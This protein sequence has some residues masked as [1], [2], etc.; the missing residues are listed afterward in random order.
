MARISRERAGGFLRSRPAVRYLAAMA[1]AM[2]LAAG[3]GTRLRPL[4]LELPKPLVWVGDRPAIAHVAGRLVAA[5]VTELVVNTHHRAEAFSEAMLAR[6][7]GRLSIVTEAEILGTG[8]GL[9]NA[10]KVLGGGDV[11][12]WNGDILA[13]LEVSD[14]LRA[15]ERWRA[16]GAGEGATLAVGPRPAGEGTV[17]LGEDGRVVRLRGEVFGEERAGG[18]FLGI[19]VVSEALRRALPIPGCL[20][21]EGLL[22]LLRSG[23][24][25][26]SFVTEAAWDDVGSIEAYLRANARWLEGRGEAYFVGDRAKVGAGVRLASSVVGEG[27]TVGGEGGIEGC[28]IWPGAAA[29]APLRGAIVT[30]GGQ[31]VTVT[32]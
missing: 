29:T 14:L 12:V 17:G 21:G 9:A 28:V 30:T 13:D 3:F 18:D 5:G 31:V 22:P 32:R 19:S 26:G 16:K 15:H 2:I 23:G 4:T 11:V 7:P 10:A 8:G 27:A 6:I 25:V 24:R 1:K 20:V